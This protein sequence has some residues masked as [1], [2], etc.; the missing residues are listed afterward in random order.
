M[1]IIFCLHAIWPQNFRVS[2]SVPIALALALAIA[3]A[4]ARMWRRELTVVDMCLD[5]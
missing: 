2:F 1:G 4:L 5:H 3:I